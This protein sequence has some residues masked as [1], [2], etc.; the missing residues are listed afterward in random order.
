LHFGGLY[1]EANQAV[2]LWQ[3][4]EDPLLRSAGLNF[5]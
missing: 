4:T 5:D 3:L 2:A 1:R